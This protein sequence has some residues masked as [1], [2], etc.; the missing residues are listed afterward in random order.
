MQI[1]STH[2][3]S[4]TLHFT[5]LERRNVVGN[6]DGGRMSSDGGG[7]LLREVE[8]QGNIIG[9]LA[10]CFEDHRDP[11]RVEHSVKR[12]VAQRV[13]G[14][15]LGYEDL[16]DHDSLR[17]DPALALALECSDITGQDRVRQRDKGH[18]LASS[19][20]LNRLELSS[21]ETAAE[22]RYKR[23]AAD[24]EE[25]DALLVNLFMDSFPAPPERIILDLDATDDVLHGN[26]ERRFYHGY[27]HTYCYLPLYIV[28]GN[29]VL[30]ARL[31][32]SNID[33]SE[34]SKQELARVVAQIRERWPEVE[35][36]IRAD[37]GFCRDAIM[38]WC[39]EHDVIY[40]LGRNKR[41]QKIIAP[42][43]EASQKQCEAT[44][45]ASRRF[46]SF[47]YKTL[48]SWSCQRRVVA[49]AEY[50]PGR[51][52]YNARF[53]VTNLAE[54]DYDARPVYEDL[55]CVRGEMENRIK[56][57]QLELFADRTSTSEMRSN[58]LRLYFSAFAHAIMARIK[59]QGLHGTEMA[60]AQRGTIRTRLFKIAAVVRVSVRR[61]KL[62]L[63]S[64][65]PWQPLF[66]RVLAN[67]RAAVPAI[68]ELVH[69][70]PAHTIA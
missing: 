58:Q 60:S 39:E 51:R 8:K 7:L 57:Q 3:P 21:E 13:F 20:T 64:T 67:L 4:N 61:C 66:E 48:K 49:K 15:C 54:E 10:E 12:L 59:E 42:D 40:I 36:W 16:N 68:P 34:G 65:Y 18:P 26:Q 53:V 24:F 17:D 35:I 41:L 11:A 43:M 47:S 70:P 55:Y 63:S 28:C 6:F 33:A 32:R 19:K 44:G 37:S 52:G 1:K 56:E 2:C 5:K 31:R 25:M 23:V 30:V 69:P 38:A 46:C 9:R 14:F 45:K 27:Y 29:H 50:L 22:G 62:A